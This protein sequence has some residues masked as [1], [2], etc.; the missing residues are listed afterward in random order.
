MWIPM[1]RQWVALGSFCMHMS[2]CISSTYLMGTVNVPSGYIPIKFQGLHIFISCCTTIISMLSP[3]I[4]GFCGLFELM[5]ILF[6]MNAIPYLKTNNSQSSYLFQYIWCVWYQGDQSRSIDWLCQQEQ[7]S[8][9]DRYQSTICRVYNCQINTYCQHSLSWFC[10]ISVFFFEKVACTHS[11]ET[12]TVG[13]KYSFKTY[14]AMRKESPLIQHKLP[15][16]V[17]TLAVCFIITRGNTCSDPKGL[18][19]CLNY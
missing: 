9:W 18:M 16:M 4:M 11:S 2:I 6:V 15:W 1:F 17:H 7:G 13:N 19:L 14:C 12:H 10:D 8:S 5:A 3:N